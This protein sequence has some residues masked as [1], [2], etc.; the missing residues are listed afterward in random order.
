MQYATNKDFLTSLVDHHQITEDGKEWL[1]LALDPF[2]D[3]NKQVAGYPDADAS[4][5]VVS[6]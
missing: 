5:T 2:H 3:Y 1:T 6:C 4:H